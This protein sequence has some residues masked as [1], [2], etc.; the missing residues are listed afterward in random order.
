MG[1]PEARLADRD[2][3]TGRLLYK[4]YDGNLILTDRGVIIRRGAKGFDSSHS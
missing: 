3:K 1:E 4:G 2:A